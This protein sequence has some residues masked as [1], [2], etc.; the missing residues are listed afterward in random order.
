MTRP[1]FATAGIARWMAMI[2]LALT[3]STTALPQAVNNAQ[4][5]GVVQD[6][7]GAMV[8]GAQVKATQTDTGRVQTTAS[9]G[10]GTYSL[11]DLMIG[12]YMLE[13]T[14]PAFS[15]YAQTGI[16]LQVGQ[17]VQVNVVL[18]VGSVSQ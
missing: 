17:N 13:V 3:A 7:T 8:A 5:H 14:S 15:K 10:D 16:V 6:S 4:I 1:G 18:S 9:S 2:I 12:A 11:P